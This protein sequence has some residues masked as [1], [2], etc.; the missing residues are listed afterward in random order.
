MKNAKTINFTICVPEALRD[1]F[2]SCCAAQDRGASA[3]LRRLMR[4]YIAK[5][6]PEGRQ[7]GQEAA[8]GCQTPQKG[9][10]GLYGALE[11]SQ[12]AA[13]LLSVQEA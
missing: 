13:Q 2:M 6:A 4:E 5:E 12:G 10:D 7:E 11:G 3:V 1:E 9:Q 8:Q